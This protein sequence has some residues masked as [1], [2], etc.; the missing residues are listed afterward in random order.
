M[1]AYR[2][3]REG[4]SNVDYKCIKARWN[5]LPPVV[6]KYMK[7]SNMILVKYG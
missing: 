7:A 6:R 3:Y 4:V 5:R 2:A 1:Y